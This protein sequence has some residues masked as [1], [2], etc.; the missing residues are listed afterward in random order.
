MEMRGRAM[1]RFSAPC[2]EPILTALNGARKTAR[3][4]AGRR[5]NLPQLPRQGRDYLLNCGRILFSTEKAS[6][7]PEG[8]SRQS[9][10]IVGSVTAV[11]A[12]AP[13]PRRGANAAW[14][15]LREGS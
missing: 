11:R 15:R 10:Q 5:D 13:K 2:H 1:I 4:D 12:G 7:H 8:N 14:G 3:R 9:A 6:S